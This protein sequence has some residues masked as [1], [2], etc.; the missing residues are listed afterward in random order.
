MSCGRDVAG[1]S[2]ACRAVAVA[3]HAKDCPCLPIEV[4]FDPK[5]DGDGRLK[6]GAKGHGADKGAG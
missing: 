1:M 5:G 4:A 6:G 2:A 3:L